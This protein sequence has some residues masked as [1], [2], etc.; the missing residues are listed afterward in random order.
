VSSDP[1]IDV[2]PPDYRHRLT[3]EELDAI[4][5]ATLVARVTALAPFVADRASEGEA[6]RKPVDEVIDRLHA[7]GVFHHFVPRR[8]G[9][10]EFGVMD[11]VDE[12][13]PLGE[14]CA[15]TCWVTVFCMEHNLLVSLYPEVVQDEIFGK[16]PYV[17]APGCAM[18]PGRAEP[19]EGGYLVS[20]RWRY[21]TGV[22]HADWA[23]G[24]AVDTTN[25][26]NARWFLLPL[27]EATV[28]DVWHMD[29]MSAT[30]SNDFA[31]DDVFVPAERSLDFS[32]MS[33]GA[34]PGAS[35]H[36]NPMYH[37]PIA[38]FLAIASAIPIIGA[39]KGVVRRFRDDLPSRVSFGV[40]QVDRPAVL[41][42]LGQAD[43]EV[44][45]AELALRESVRDLM[46]LAESDDR[47][48][49]GARAR[50]RANVVNATSLARE[51]VRRVIDALGTTV[52]QSDHP[53]QRA[54]RDITVAT[55]HVLHDRTAAM[56]LHGR[57]LLGL[58]PQPTL[59]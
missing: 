15:S 41:M 32:E 54:V 35:L 49:I 31:I 7:T 26:H 13:L 2:V 56:E 22:M 6:A 52:H 39:A 40:P 50:L 3:A 57:L 20:G 4:T 23:M 14:A 55:A 27:A 16:Q 37:V 25:R 24:L 18:P 12:M 58:P 19:V 43:T 44:N 34:T 21:A 11:F 10:L 33:T 45:L 29:G 51:S 42:A 48:N 5:P 53:T 1:V 8:Y 9:G 38:P 59:Y 47:A 28:F 30:G 46:R 17:M 36:P